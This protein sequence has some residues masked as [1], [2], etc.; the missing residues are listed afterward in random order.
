MSD[1]RVRVPF[2][3]RLADHV[4]L[5]RQIVDGVVKPWLVDHLSGAVY[6]LTEAE[7]EYVIAMDGTRDFGGVILD[8]VRRDHFQRASQVQELVGQLQQANMLVDGIAPPDPPPVRA[9]KRPLEPLA[10]FRLRCDGHGACCTAF[11]SVPFTEQEVRRAVV[12]CPERVDG[13]LDRMFLPLWGVVDRS[14]S[15]VTM[16]EG[17]CPF[18]ADTGACLVHERAGAEAKP[19]GCRA[20]PRT[21]I[22]DGTAVRV[23]VRAEC[24][25]VVAS[26]VGDA[27][28]G[29]TL[30]DQGAKVEGDLHPRIRVPRLPAEIDLARG[31]VVPVDSLR[32]WSAR[33]V[34]AP[35]TDGVAAL[36]ALADGATKNL[37]GSV[38]EIVRRPPPTPDVL[39]PCIAALAE[40]AE[41]RRDAA[42]DRRPTDRN[43]LLAEWVVAAAVALADTSTAAARLDEVSDIAQE[44]FYIQ[45]AIWGHHLVERGGTVT[46]GLR[47]RAIRLL[48]ARQMAEMAAN[49]DDPATAT[50]IA[51]VE[52]VMR[53]QALEKY[54]QA[55]PPSL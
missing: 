45:T 43:R 52:A 53:G 51:A 1:D 47:D 37:D 24:P 50:P 4:M 55:W 19:L 33:V 16:T 31:T 3:P 12:A 2:R 27:V 14:T 20:F 46:T 48:L 7:M 36:W 17:R 35:I 26:G 18:V 9:P 41:L 32:S 28:D 11:A 42:S 21:F 34:A 25:C 40:V 30:L 5:R 44:R 49:I 6:A 23:S 38:S 54:V 10:D 29:E 8:I 22:D 39:A 15:A 13:P